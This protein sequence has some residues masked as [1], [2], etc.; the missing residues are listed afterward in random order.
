MFNF[1]D[2]V[3]ISKYDL[4]FRNGYKPQLTQN[5]FEFVAISTKKRATYTMKDEQD[6]IIRGNLYQR[7][8]IGV[9]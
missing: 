2:R 7:E 9:I 5:V 3:R 1:G 8:L 4:P 6:D